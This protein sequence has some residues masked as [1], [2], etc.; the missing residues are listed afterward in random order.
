MPPWPRGSAPA[1]GSSSEAPQLPAEPSVPARPA[2]AAAPVSRPCA[3]GPRVSGFG[4]VAH[5]SAVPLESW[6]APRRAGG[7]GLAAQPSPGAALGAEA[8]TQHRH[9]RPPASSATAR[10]P[11]VPR[12]SPAWARVGWLR[13]RAAGP[14]VS[15]P[16]PDGGPATSKTPWIA[17]SSSGTA[18]PARA[19]AA[20]RL[21]GAQAALR[22]CSPEQVFGLG[23][24]QAAPPPRPRPRP[25][26]PRPRVSP[27]GAQVVR[28]RRVQAA[29]PCPVR[30][31]HTPAA[32]AASVAA[33]PGSRPAWRRPAGALARPRARRRAALR[34]C[35]R[36]YQV[37]WARA[38]PP[39]DALG[40]R[41]QAAAGAPQVAPCG[42]PRPG[43]LSRLLAP[44]G[45]VGR[46]ARERAP[47][48]FPCLA[49][50]GRQSR[51]SGSASPCP[52]A[53]SASPPRCAATTDTPSRRG[54]G[55]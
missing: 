10:H 33:K 11:R 17:T 7:R 38:R 9:G 42:L 55:S 22:G 30:V 24:R 32:W 53:A 20:P 41:G 26:G 6:P 13:Q 18:R 34:S 46:P 2:R 43:R 14:W 12:G 27:T 44:L 47:R 48:R 1:T 31:A 21:A 52:P 49:A 36:S 5:R 40:A 37:T 4:P 15:L 29:L 23:P 39:A 35:R 19:R 28:Q 45:W 51:R 50:W 8:A 25:P 3:P 16:R 54:S